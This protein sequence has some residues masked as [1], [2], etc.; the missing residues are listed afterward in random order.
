MTSWTTTRKRPSGRHSSLL[1]GGEDPGPAEGP[2]EG[3]DG[4]DAAYWARLEGGTR[5]SIR[6]QNPGQVSQD[7]VVLGEPGLFRRP[8]PGTGLNRPVP[9]RRWYRRPGPLLGLLAGVALIAV[10][11]FLATPPLLALLGVGAQTCPQCSMPIPSSAAIG[12]GTGASAAMSAPASHRPRPAR[13]ASAPPP[14]QVVAPQP[15]ATTPSA[16][17]PPALAATY[18]AFGTGGDGFA[19]QVTLTNQGPAA[20]SNW[21]LVVALPGDDI[22]AVQ[23]AEF[24]DDNDVLFMTPAPADLTIEPGASIAVTI[25]ASGP[26]QTPAECSFNNVAC[27]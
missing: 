10:T 11:G 26:T 5:V 18:T 20:I 25:Y 7:T 6:G 4:A 21:Q 23:N 27:Q 15:T 24:N 19:G 16:P 2:D 22:S 9:A 14:V 3:F 8:P 1:S 12:P 17:P 13:T